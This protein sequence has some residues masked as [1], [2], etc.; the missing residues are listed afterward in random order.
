MTNVMK[1][2]TRV[3]RMQ[4]DSHTARN[5]TKVR[6]RRISGIHHKLHTNQKMLRTGG[7]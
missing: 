6:Q 5:P 2:N 4:K 7:S 1:K 3:I